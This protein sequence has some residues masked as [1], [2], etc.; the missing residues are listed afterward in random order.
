[1]NVKSGPENIPV[2]ALKADIVSSV[3][4]LHSLF[5][6]IWEEELVPSEWREGILV[7]LPKNGDLSNCSKY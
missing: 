5:S 1:M 4:M 3:N 7:K 6:K 2:A